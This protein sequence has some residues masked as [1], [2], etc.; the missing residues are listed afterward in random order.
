[1]FLRSKLDFKI[2]LMTTSS[3]SIDPS[4]LSQAKKLVDDRFNAATDELATLVRIP[5]IAWEA[6]EPKNL[7]LSAET[8]AQLFREIGVF[9]IVEV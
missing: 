5:G 2:T 9:E 8:I 1:M 7:E 3:I 6:F 4:Q